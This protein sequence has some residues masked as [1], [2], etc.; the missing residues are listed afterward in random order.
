M[1]FL[2]GAAAF[3]LPGFPSLQASP[4]LQSS[5]PADGKSPPGGGEP[6]IG[7]QSLPTD[8]LLEEA[9]DAVQ[10]HDFVI[11]EALYQTVLLRERQN[12]HAILELAEVYE[13]TGKLEYARGLLLR[14]SMLRPHDEKI[15]EKI[16]EISELL[17]SVLK[18]EVDSLISRKQCELALPKLSMLLTIEPENPDLYFKKAVCYLAVGKPKTALICIDD[19]LRLQKDV[20]YF[21]L[22]A[23][24]TKRIKQN[25][26]DELVE[27]ARSLLRNDSPSNRERALQ[28]IGEILQIDPEHA[29]AKQSFVILSKGEAPS[30]QLIEQGAAESG[31][32]DESGGRI[33]KRFLSFSNIPPIF[34]DRHMLTLLAVAVAALV[35]VISTFA[36]LKRKPHAC[37]LS[38]R[39]SH[40]SLREILDLIKATSR[41][42]VLRINS[43][44]T[45]GEIYFSDGE[46]CHCKTGK[47]TGA[48]AFSVLIS[49]IRAGSFHFLDCAPPIKQMMDTYSIP[50]ASKPKSKASAA[51]SEGSAPARSRRPKTRMRELLESK[52]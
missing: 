31:E 22:H 48:Q 42:G 24:I 52:K 46:M 19:A 26:I 44:F 14:A 7:T 40:F 17:S 25:E 23:E 27:S 13:K 51:D 47:L 41:T 34:R 30:I 5:D 32:I 6:V 4:I 39:F 45:N 21:N 37:P 16:R 10:R 8:F 50:P 43:K 35:L 2:A 36:R 49:K 9:R 11:A 29:W 1:V 18:E 12:M 15:I 33:Q 20:E 28:T 38:G 3:C